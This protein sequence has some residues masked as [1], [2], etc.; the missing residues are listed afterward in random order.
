[1]PALSPQLVSLSRTLRVAPIG[2]GT[3]SWGNSL[4]YQYSQARD[5]ELSRCYAKLLDAGLPLLF[6]TADSYGAGGRAELLLGRFG[7]ERRASARSTVGSAVVATKL[8]PFPTRL[9]RGAFLSAAKESAAR[10]QALPV[11][12]GQAHWSTVNYG[13]SQEDALLSGLCDA[14]DAGVFSSVGLSNYGPKQLARAEAALGA[15]GVRVACLQIQYSLLSREPERSGLIEVA[16]RL[17]IQLIAYSPLALGLLGS[18][19]A[20]KPPP[21]LRGLLFRS[22]RDDTAPLRSLLAEI[23]ASRSAA[24]GGAARVT[25]SQVAVNWTRARGFLPIVGVNT[26]AQAQELIDAAEWEL[27]DGEV[28][29]LDAASAGLRQVQQNIFQT[30]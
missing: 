19:A 16:K 10:L 24:G 7:A 12:I 9:T 17:G 3:W 5:A 14:V 8:A 30:P 18:T 29:A 25:A 11:P 26:V 21:G 15:R 27:T 4:L 2:V 6:D 23:A 13:G 20:R 1:M 22:R 28:A